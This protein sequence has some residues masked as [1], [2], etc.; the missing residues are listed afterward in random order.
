[1]FPVLKVL[2]AALCVAVLLPLVSSCGTNSRRPKALVIGLDGGTWKLLRPWMEKGDLP[3]LKELV[4]SGVSGDLNS[5]VPFLSP[6]AWTSAITGVNPGKHGIYDFLRRIPGEGTIVNET[7]RS[8]RVDPIWLILSEAGF[9]CGVVNVPAT[10][11][12]DALNGFM[13]SGMPHVGVTG[14]TYPPE[15]EK[16]LKGYKT[17][18]M[19]T[20][21]EPGK[22]EVLLDEIM[23]TM[24]ARNANVEELLKTKDWDFAWVVV[25]ST[26][27]I[28]H[29]F[30]Q[31]MDPEWPNYDAEKAARFGS[32]IHDLW[33]EVDGHVG[34]LVSA[35][36]KKY[37]DDLPILIVSDHG[38]GPVHREFRM[39]SFLR[40]PPAG[41][42]PITTAYSYETNGALLYFN[43]EGR[44]PGGVLPPDQLDAEKAEVIRRL[45]GA[46]DPDT[47]SLP[48]RDIYTREQ[49]Y[50]G[51]YSEKGPD[52]VMTP[53]PEVYISNDKGHRE[54]WGTPSYSFSAHH[55]M[56][57]IFVG[58]GGPF[59]TGH[60]DSGASLLDVTP[61]LLYLLGQP[62]P[63]YCDGQVLAGIFTPEFVKKHPVS[64]VAR[65][66]D[67]GAPAPTGASGAP[68]A[69][70]GSTPASTVPYI[71]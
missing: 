19:D 62:V 44:E 46:R 28:Q 71:H 49:A 58:V 21:L 60:L 30:W 68:G 7:S 65:A 35:A 15:L 2:S 36:R 17:D 50:R 23:T 66:S 48:M 52:V 26:D 67:Q 37:G 40:N 64:S 70:A 18:R 59:R 54:P 5:V 63:D 1:M 29:F 69:P 56:E 38:F 47:G 6:P 4:D 16:E 9:R 32:S 24:R 10:D 42:D 8:R 61:T 43:V 27:R 14:Y 33:V 55:E 20:S 12:P 45:E 39:Q 51:R 11:P 53:S 31:F 13:I 25:T 57:G 41:Q 22:E 3:N 34:R